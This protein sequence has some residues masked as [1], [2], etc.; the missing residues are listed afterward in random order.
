MDQYWC[1]FEFDAAYRLVDEGRRNYIVLVLVEKPTRNK[2]TPELK[3]YL[4]SHTYI[5]R[6]SRYFKDVAS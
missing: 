2:L 5:D 4:Q 3:A 1:R 6:M